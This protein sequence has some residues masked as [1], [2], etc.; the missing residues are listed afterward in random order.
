M[1]LLKVFWPLINWTISAIKQKF[2]TALYSNFFKVQ[3]ALAIR[4]IFICE[5]A[6][7]HW[8]NG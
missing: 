6:Y 4:G 5:F 2:I 1:T 8:K 3:A 7:S